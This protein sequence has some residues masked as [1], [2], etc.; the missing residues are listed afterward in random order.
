MNRNSTQDQLSE[1]EYAFD[2][3]LSAAIRVKGTTREVAEARLRAALN[4]ADCNGGAWPDGDPILFEASVNNALVLYEVDGEPVEQA[5]LPL[6]AACAAL[7]VH[8]TCLSIAGDAS[9]QV[10]QLLVSLRRF[11]ATNGL[12]IDATFA[13]LRRQAY[14]ASEPIPNIRVRADGDANFY[15]LLDSSDWVA[16]IQLNGK[17][18]TPTQEGMM[19]KFADALR[20]GEAPGGSAMSSSRQGQAGRIEGMD[21]ISV[22]GRRYEWNQVFSAYWSV[23]GGPRALQTADLL[24]AQIRDGKLQEVPET[25]SYVIHSKS[26]GEEDVDGTLGAFWSNEDGWGGFEA[27]TRFT[28][29]E[30]MKRGSGSQLPLSCNHDAEWLSIQEVFALGAANS[31]PAV[32]EARVLGDYQQML[33]KIVLVR[34]VSGYRGTDSVDVRLNPPAKVRVA[35]TEE[36]SLK[37]WND[38]WCD[39]YWEVELVEPHPQLEGIRSIWISGNCYHLD[40]QQTNVSDVISVLADESDEGQAGLSQGA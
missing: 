14:G 36:P 17:F 28:G 37:H 32:I 40:G 2:C 30:R 13:D 15:H 6:V 11:C 16:A 26:E 3:N 25:A 1:H 34:V 20:S 24:G 7:E 18:T 23:D 38:D 4:T 8:S 31:D 10:R 33:G 19:Q 9:V 5:D 29:D 39:P 35:R 12:D 21:L 27:A 22:N